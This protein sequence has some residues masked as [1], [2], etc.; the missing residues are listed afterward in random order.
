MTVFQEGEELTTAANFDV[1]AG[2]LNFL[3][4]LDLGEGLRF[5][6]IVN[7]ELN[8]FEMGMNCLPYCRR[9]GTDRDLE[10]QGIQ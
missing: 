9:K 5:A 7:Y 4:R 2:C 1:G 3:G 10:T 8:K 6:A